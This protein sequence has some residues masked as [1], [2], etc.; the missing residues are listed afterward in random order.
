MCG[1]TSVPGARKATAPV[2]ISLIPQGFGR[3]QND[4]WP[5]RGPANTEDPPATSPHPGCPEGAQGM[6]G[7]VPWHLPW[8][9]QLCWHCPHPDPRSPPASPVP[10]RVPVCPLLL[11]LMP[12][13][14]WA[15]ALRAPWPPRAAPSSAGLSQSSAL[16]VVTTLCPFPSPGRPLLQEMSFFNST[17]DLFL[18]EIP[19]PCEAR[20]G[21]LRDV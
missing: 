9:Q 21:L 1:D 19:Q 2:L 10:S 11:L 12:R 15:S 7:Q 16:P 3:I 13:E 17:W 8:P 14:R 6:T 4:K 5:D 20:L 18:L